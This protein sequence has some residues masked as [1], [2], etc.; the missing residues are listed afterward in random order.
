MFHRTD[1]ISMAAGLLVATAAMAQAQA[2]AD[3]PAG[4]TGLCRDGT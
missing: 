3:A 2:P 4:S 1:L